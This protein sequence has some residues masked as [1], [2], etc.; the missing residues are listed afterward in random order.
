VTNNGPGGFA[1]GVGKRRERLTMKRSALARPSCAA[2]CATTKPTRESG[3]H[4]QR[5]SLPHRPTDS[6]NSS[7]GP[8]MESLAL[9]PPTGGGHD[10]PVLRGDDRA[11]PEGAPPTSGA[12]V[13]YLESVGESE[14]TQFNLTRGQNPRRAD[15]FTPGQ[16]E[17]KSSHSPQFDRCD[18]VVVTRRDDGDISAPRP[19]AQ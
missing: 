14:C 12:L 1:V 9:T 2:K 13:E 11:P 4:F 16:L 5:A 19:R 18:G 6:E 15:A 3:G 8:S 10:E 17:Q 7:R